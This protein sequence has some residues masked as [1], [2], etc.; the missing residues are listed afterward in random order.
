MADKLSADSQNL[1]EKESVEFTDYDQVIIGGSIYYGSIHS[2]ISDFIEKTTDQ[3]LKKKVALFLV[4]MLSEETA[5]EQFN[6]NYSEELLAHSVADGFF[7]G[8]LQKEQL[9]PVEKLVTTFTFRN[10]DTFDK[11]YYDEVDKF[12]DQ[13][14]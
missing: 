10:N 2:L 5:A 8:T 6:N 12:L 9:N 1:L 14:K 7:G 3:L 11:I 13:L 4:C